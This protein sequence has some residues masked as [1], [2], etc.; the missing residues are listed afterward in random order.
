MEPRVRR[1]PRRIRLRHHHP[2]PIDPGASTSTS[3]TGEPDPTA[4]TDGAVVPTTGA[5]TTGATTSTTSDTTGDA[6]TGEATTDEATTGD[7]IE[8][9]HI[10]YYGDGQCG[11]PLWCHALDNDPSDGE[12]QRTAAQL[13]FRPDTLPPYRLTRIG[14]VIAKT[15]GNVGAGSLIEVFTRGPDGAPDDLILTAQLSAGALTVEPHA[16]VFPDPPEIA[17]R[18]FCVGLV[19]G[20]TGGDG[21]G[22]GVGTDPDQMAAKRSWLNF[23]DG[24]IC[25]LSGWNDV[26][27]LMPAA[28]GTWCIDVTVLGHVP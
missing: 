21:A 27:E 19:G 5:T 3:T 8:E 7:T 17:A 9:E 18:E 16:F 15:F 2:A 28:N 6:T 1:A 12:P 23:S 11:V 13:C 24:G 10:R 4:T 22:L 20:Y 25:E 14:Y 26:D